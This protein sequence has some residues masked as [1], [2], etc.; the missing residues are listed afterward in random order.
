MKFER[1]QPMGVAP[2]RSRSV[3]D[4]AHAHRTPMGRAGHGFF[5]NGCNDG[6]GRDVRR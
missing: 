6:P 4:E 5:R 3:V 2:P 1:I